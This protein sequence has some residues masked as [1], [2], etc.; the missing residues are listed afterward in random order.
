MVKNIPY[1]VIIANFDDFS[2]PVFSA[3]INNRQH[4]NAKLTYYNQ[5]IYKINEKVCKPFAFIV[6]FEI[7]SLKNE[8]VSLY[9]I[10]F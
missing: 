7:F 3:C 1:S 5:E 6:V 2:F 8:L 10:I 9:Q 4:K